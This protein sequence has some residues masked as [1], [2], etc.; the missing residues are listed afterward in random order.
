M[1]YLYCYDIADSRRLTKV[2]RLLEE[3]GI[4][5]QKSF[6][7]CDFESDDARTLLNNIQA[8]LKLEFDSIFLYPICNKCQKQVRAVGNGAYQF[9]EDFKIL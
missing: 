2:A 1:R 7:I 9:L 4:R 8:Q 6:F 3:K 5:V